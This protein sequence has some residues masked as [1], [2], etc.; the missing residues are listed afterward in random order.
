MYGNMLVEPLAPDYYNEV[1]REEVVMLDDLL[2]GE[3][4]V[5]PFGAE[6]A[7][8]MLMGRFGNTFLTNGEPE[9]GLD[10]RAGDGLQ[11]VADAGICRVAGARVLPRA[12][13]IY[14]H[15]APA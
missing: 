6:S 15:Q 1:D 13:G 2:L 5:V 14:R 7:N 4:D 9:Y 8:Y 11:G 12:R 10:V 3:D